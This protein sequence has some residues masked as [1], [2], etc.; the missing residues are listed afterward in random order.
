MPQSEQLYMG[1]VSE[2]DGLD[3]IELGLSHL[4]MCESETNTEAVA[5]EGAEEEE[6][7]TD[8]DEDDEASRD[9]GSPPIFVKPTPF[10]IK[11]GG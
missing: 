7:T 6:E 11:A 3:C 10:P 2:F 5:E 4:E 1:S 9:E 8:E